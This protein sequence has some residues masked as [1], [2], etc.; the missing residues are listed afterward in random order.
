MEKEFG[1]TL[2]V[3][4][5]FTPAP[6]IASAARIPAPPEASEPGIFD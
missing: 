6:A 2:P 4:R 1:P 5:V 3:K